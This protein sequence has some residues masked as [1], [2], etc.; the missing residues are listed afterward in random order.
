MGTPKPKK[1]EKISV[2]SGTASDIFTDL[3]VSRRATTR[4]QHYISVATKSLRLKGYSP[5]VLVYRKDASTGKTIL[6]RKAAGTNVETA[7]ISASGTATITKHR[8]KAKKKAAK[9]KAKKK[10]AKKKT[11]KK[12]AKKKTKKK[13]AKKKTK[14][15]AAKKKSNKKAARRKSKKRATRR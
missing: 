15:K 9:K 10:A 14:K 5:T 13:V 6:V 4:A 8:K 1:S 11:N 2:S 7:K 12:V 3:D